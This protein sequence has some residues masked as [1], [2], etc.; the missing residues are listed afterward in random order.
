[1][2]KRAKTAAGQSYVILPEAAGKGYS[3]YGL[4]HRWQLLTRLKVGH[5]PCHHRRDGHEEHQGAQPEEFS[6]CSGR[7]EPTHKKEA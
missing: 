3:L 6:G 4:L 5:L 7:G 2:A 1:M